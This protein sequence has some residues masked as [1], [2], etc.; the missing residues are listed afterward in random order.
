MKKIYGY[1]ALFAAMSL[2]SCSSDNEPNVTLG[3]A[4]TGYIGIKIAAPGSLTRATADEI[5][6]D[7]ESNV[8]NALLVVF[9]KDSK[10]VIDFKTFVPEKWVAGAADSDITKYSENTVQVDIPEGKAVGEVICVLNP[11]SL[12]FTKVTDNLTT[13]RKK[14][15]DFSST[16]S[17]E[18]VMSSSA[19]GETPVYTTD[20]S[21]AVKPTKEEAQAAAQNIYVER[22]L[23]KATYTFVTDFAVDE[24]KQSIDGTETELDIH[25]TGI[26]MANEASE[27]YLVKDIDKNSGWP[28]FSVAG[29]NA[30]GT[31][32]SHWAD[33][34]TTLATNLKNQKY[35]DIVKGFA[36]NEGKKSEPIYLYENT[37]NT[38]G[39]NT[40]VLVTAQ[41]CKKGTTDG[42]TIYLLGYNNK[43]YG[44]EGI[45]NQVANMLYDD[46]YRKKDGE[47]WVKIEPTDIS[48]VAAPTDGNTAR[49]A[50]Q[51]YAQVDDT[52]TLGVYDAA[53]GTYTEKEA[54]TVNNE[55]KDAVAFSDSK[56]KYWVQKWDNGKCYYYKDVNADEVGV[57]GIVRNHVYNLTLNGVGGMGT[58]IFD[59][60]NPIIPEDPDPFDP[61]TPNESY[62]SAKINILNWTVYTQ[63][64]NFGTHE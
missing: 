36:M 43:Y 45:H 11:G 7:A 46:D 18:F 60:E 29:F 8:T 58:P 52:L 48:F 1:A 30:F 38:K 23:A 55:I 54:A 42:V 51:G 34:T 27:T 44:E 25:I 4:E 49:A 61:G 40:A 41:L 28:T 56:I 3:Q 20:F 64:V 13:V 62:L 63:S 21:N 14:I 22:V 39:Q 31:Y 32:R 5:G 35:D 26:E 6:T 33:P 59:P 9:D 47:N 16:K 37:L 12:S 19:Y 15:A 10:E 2:A 24:L 17:G 57:P 50:Y 53:T